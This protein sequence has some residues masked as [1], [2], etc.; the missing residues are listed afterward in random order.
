MV[1]RHFDPSP[2]FL[3]DLPRQRKSQA[4]S[5]HRL[6]TLAAVKALKDL[7]DLL[8]WDSISSVGNIDSAVGLVAFQG[9][10]HPSPLRGILDRIVQDVEDGLF[11]PLWVT[12][13]RNW[14][15]RRLDREI[16]FF[17]LC[18]PTYLQRS[19]ENQFLYFSNPWLKADA[20]GLQ[21]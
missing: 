20:P 8:R 6:H 18:R 17:T 4:H 13:H 11:R 15:G 16:D 19:I 10:S 2:L 9:K 3:N 21:T 5:F 1:R 14:F 12:A 7:R